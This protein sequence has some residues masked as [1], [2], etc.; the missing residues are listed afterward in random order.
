MIDVMTSEESQA[1]LTKKKR[2]SRENAVLRG[3][4]E[5]LTKYVEALPDC[6]YRFRGESLAYTRDVIELPPP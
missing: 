3:R 4:A 1:L 5:E 6:D 2:L